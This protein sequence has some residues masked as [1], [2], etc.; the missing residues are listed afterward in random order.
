MM[1]ISSLSVFFL[2]YFSSSSSSPPSSSLLLSLPYYDNQCSTF[3]T[4]ICCVHIVAGGSSLDETHHLVS[5]PAGIVGHHGDGHRL[6][7]AVLPH[8]AFPAPGAAAGLL[9]EAGL[10]PAAGHAAAH[11]RRETHEE[12]R[13]PQNHRL[14]PLCHQTPGGKHTCS[15][16]LLSFVNNTAHLPVPLPQTEQ[17]F[18]FCLINWLINSLLRLKDKWTHD[19]L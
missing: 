2:V 3:S 7:A 9:Q 13:E 11:L 12:G 4:F 17:L 10:R 14:Q 15:A 18:R 19:C 6:A 5:C 16:L 1:H 8:A